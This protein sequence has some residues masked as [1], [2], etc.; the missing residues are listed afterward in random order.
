MLSKRFLLIAALLLN[1]IMTFATEPLLF[2]DFTCGYGG[3]KTYNFAAKQ[4]DVITWDYYLE[5]A[6]GY[7][8][9]SQRWNL[10]LSYKVTLDGEV[11]ASITHGDKGGSSK[12]EGVQ[13][14]EI[15]NNGSHELTIKFTSES[16]N[17]RY[18]KSSSGSAKIT[19]IA[20]NFNSTPYSPE[21]ACGENASYSFSEDLTLTITGTGATSDY[22]DP[23]EC[24]WLPYKNQ[25][26]VVIVNQGIESI[27]TNAFSDIHSLE[28][29]ILPEA[30]T[31][32]GDYA[33]ANCDNLHHFH[34]PNSL[35]TLG[36]SAFEGCS[37]LTEIAIPSSVT[38]IGKDA[39]KDCSSL[40][41]IAVAWSEPLELADEAFQGVG[42]S[43]CTLYVPVG[44]KDKYTASST[45]SSFNIIERCASPTIAFQD[46]KL[47]FHS[48]TPD[49]QYMY[50]VEYDDNTSFSIAGEFQDFRPR[51]TVTA[52]T[53]LEGCADSEMTRR[54]FYIA[55][56][57]D[58]LRG[59]VNRDTRISISDVSALVDLLLH[60][61]DVQPEE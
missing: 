5:S 30:L 33:F 16:D 4:G 1:C 11:V 6:Y 22:T 44:S 14:I 28:S 58:C 51:F 19:N 53:V 50:K 20:L 24:P 61:D 39:F 17:Y 29:V 55:D 43:T 13:T 60:K 25:I 37:A 36:T 35:T 34:L 15:P 18:R 42:Q 8:V 54:T 12:Y 27:G 59:D 38:S 2:E 23:S 32:I 45:W 48:D 49:A 57:D 21:G 46:G 7:D 41:E 47:L 10:S 9:Y 40:R 52:F 26:T 31:S 3:T 56:P